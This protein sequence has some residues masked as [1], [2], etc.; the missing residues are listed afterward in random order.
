MKYSSLA[1]MSI[2]C[3]EK[4][5][6]GQPLTSLQSCKSFDLLYH[7]GYQGRSQSPRRASPLGVSPYSQ[8]RSRSI[9][10]IYRSRSLSPQKET[11][12]I[13]S[14]SAL[15]AVPTPVRGTT[16][17]AGSTSASTSSR[18]SANTVTTT[19]YVTTTP[20]AATLSQRAT[21]PL[22]AHHERTSKIYTSG[23]PLSARTSGSLG[24]VSS[25]SLGATRESPNPK[26]KGAGSSTEKSRV[27]PGAPASHQLK[28][29]MTHLSFRQSPNRGREAEIQV[30][31][32]KSHHSTQSKQVS[33]SSIRRSEE[34]VVGGD[35][36]TTGKK[37]VSQMNLVTKNALTPVEEN[38]PTI[39]SG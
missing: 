38:L 30:H 20:L 31:H 24:Y 29:N 5:R 1:D 12:S 18:T 39:A 9:S 36:S 10:P 13:N 16:P 27:P 11:L 3:F 26:G 7:E 2:E 28:F 17:R 34:P 23:K 37:E 8:V 35:A 22:D 25:L 6:R 19:P 14:A 32:G 33:E 15:V 21:T 4:S